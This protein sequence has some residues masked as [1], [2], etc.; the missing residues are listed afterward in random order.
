[1][2]QLVRFGSTGAP[3]NLAA[4]SVPYWLVAVVM[5]P[6]LCTVM[7]VG[8]GYEPRILG[9]GSEEFRRV[10]NAAVRFLALVVVAFYALDVDLA[11]GFVAAFVPLAT[12]LTLLGRYGARRWLHARRGRSR[13]GAARGAV[14]GTITG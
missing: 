1:M 3:A 11:R 9:V 10:F 6:V 5:V 13:H 8:G 2:A 14:T 12:V 7:A 4:T